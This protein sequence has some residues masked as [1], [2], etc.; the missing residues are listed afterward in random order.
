MQRDCSSSDVTAQRLQITLVHGTWGRGFF[1]DRFRT[2]WAVPRWFE[3]HSKFSAELYKNLSDYGICCQ[4]RAFLWSGANSIEARDRAA[5]ELKNLIEAGGIDQPHLVIGHSHG[6]NVAVRALSLLRE[7]PSQQTMVVTLATPF[8][9]VF[10]RKLGVAEDYHIALTCF[11]VPLLLTALVFASLLYF[12]IGILQ[13]DDFRYRDEWWNLKILGLELFKIFTV[14]CGIGI[15]AFSVTKFSDLFNE[16]LIGLS[17][18]KFETSSRIGKHV[19]ALIVRSVDDEP[20]LGFAIGALGNRIVA[21]A[22][23]VCVFLVTMCPVVILLYVVIAIL[24]STFFNVDQN[25]LFKFFP[26]LLLFAICVGPMTG[27]ICILLSGAMRS[28]FG[29][30]LLFGAFRQ[31]VAFNSTPDHQGAITIET[32][33]S[34]GGLRH[35]IYDHVDCSTAIARWAKIASCVP[36]KSV[37][38]GPSV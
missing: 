28:I 16:K 27:V 9:D 33:P 37:P 6:G 25:T 5:R 14:W 22:L 31:D 26:F 36:Q 12:F 1:P 8:L 38:D 23:Q 30:E 10:P 4:I 11:A 13:L 35:S 34:A 21:T 19:S 24:A 32:L 15:G 18:R 17:E 20:F 3:A 2:K 29:R 7:Q